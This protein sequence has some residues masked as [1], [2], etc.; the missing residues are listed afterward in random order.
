M[1]GG[2]I[3]EVTHCGPQFPHTCPIISPDWSCLWKD[4]GTLLV[5]PQT[6]VGWAP[7]EGEVSSHHWTWEAG[8]G[9]KSP[10]DCS[11]FSEFLISRF[12]CFIPR[13]SYRGQPRPEMEDKLAPPP[14]SIFSRSLKSEPVVASSK[15]FPS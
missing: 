12:H 13:L 14:T 3:P 8:L 5:E 15:S 10:K 9:K 6:A 1:R 4:R 2:Q 7:R 11:S